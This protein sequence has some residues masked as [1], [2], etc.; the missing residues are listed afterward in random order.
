MNMLKR[1][2]VR[3]AVLI[4]AAVMIATGIFRGEVGMILQKA[5]MIC[6]ECIGIG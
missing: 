5:A 4:A 3:I 6:F 2:V 1:F